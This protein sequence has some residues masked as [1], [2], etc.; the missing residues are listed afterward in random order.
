MISIKQVKCWQRIHEKHSGLPVRLSLFPVCNLQPSGIIRFQNGRSPARE[1]GGAGATVFRPS[2]DRGAPM[3]VGPAVAALPPCKGRW[4]HPSHW[5]SPRTAA[6]AGFRCRRLPFTA[7]RFCSLRKRRDRRPSRRVGC[8]G[9]R[10][11]RRRIEHR[12]PRPRRLR[13]SNHDAGG[14]GGFPNRH[15]RIQVC[16]PQFP[17]PSKRMPWTVILVGG[18]TTLRVWGGPVGVVGHMRAPAFAPLRSFCVPTG[19]DALQASLSAQT[20]T[21]DLSRPEGNVMHG[22]RALT[23]RIR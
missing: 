1:G 11:G 23:K 15:A 7:A 6:V 9:G 5:P 8:G 20:G 2:P 22:D 18:N 12:N 10:F 4:F 14:E 3:R 21:A 16:G 13:Y 17:H 19:G